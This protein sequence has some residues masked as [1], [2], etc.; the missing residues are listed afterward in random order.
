LTILARPNK[1]L[2]RYNLRN[3]Y[4]LVARTDREHPAAIIP[5]RPAARIELR[6]C[7]LRISWD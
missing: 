5:P 1:L 3:F 6:F 7:A 2:W 4:G